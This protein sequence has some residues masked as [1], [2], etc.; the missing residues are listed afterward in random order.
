VEP[1]LQDT[2][3]IRV[4]AF[5]WESVKGDVS[6]NWAIVEQLLDD[7]RDKKPHL[8]VMPEMGLTGYIWRDKTAIA[9]LAALCSSHDVQNQWVEAAKRFDVWL[10]VGHPGVDAHTGSLRNRCTLVS[11]GGIVGHYDKT[12]LFPE[13][14]HWAD[15]GNHPPPIWET[16]WGKVA[17][18]ICADMDYPEPL[19]HAVAHGAELIAFCTAWVEEPAPSAVWTIR[20]HELGV[21]IVAADLF[22]VDQEVVFSGG[23]CIIDSTGTVIDSLDYQTGVV[24]ADLTLGSGVVPVAGNTR[25]I[26]RVQLASGGVAGTLH[27]DVAVAGATLLRRIDESLEHPDADIVVLPA[28]TVTDDSERELMLDSVQDLA[29]RSQSIVVGSVI[30]QRTGMALVVTS[31][32]GARCHN[33]AAAHRGA[34]GVWQNNSTS[35]QVGEF[36]LG[37]V[38]VAVVGAWELR[39]FWVIRALAASGV[40]LVVATGPASLTSPR[41]R[42][43]SQAPFT[44]PLGHAEP[45]FAH[46]GRF[47]AGDSNVWLAFA[48]ASVD[49]PGG[50]FSP[51]HV[52]WPRREV[53]ADAT[54]W[55]LATCTADPSDPWGDQSVAKPLVSAR[56]RDLFPDVWSFVGEES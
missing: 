7:S 34:D 37:D 41:Q 35:S 12:C 55:A 32:Q 49:T 43:E 30:D 18:L 10:V 17:P 44:L 24:T 13:D 16:P 33:V 23:S 2:R 52:W 15:P 56:R 46:P 36:S 53:L 48:S 40:H 50:I 47:R 27:V 6:A 51:N 45:Y 4:A 31:H 29:K 14:T 38:R 25:E 42:A 20:A 1:T 54:S 26:S 39:H 8:V 21:P 11:P 3:T 28:L 9:P 19:H 22:G 5:Q